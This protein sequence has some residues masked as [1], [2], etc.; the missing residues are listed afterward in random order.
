M[1]AR[2]IRD[3]YRRRNTAVKILYRR[4]RRVRDLLGR[5]ACSQTAGTRACPGALP[6]CGSGDGAQLVVEDAG[7]APGQTVVV[8]GAAGNVGAFAIQIARARDANIV[9]TIRAA[10]DEETVRI[11]GAT[12]VIRSQ[13]DHA[14]FAKGADVVIDTV[15]GRSQGSPFSLVRPSPA[16]LLHQ[17]WRI[18]RRWRWIPLISG[19]GA[20]APVNE[21]FVALIR[22]FQRQRAW[23]RRRGRSRRIPQNTSQ[24]PSGRAC[25]AHPVEAIA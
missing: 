7:V 12:Q 5:H 16:T 14:R 9:G 25:R 2:R 1:N 22:K 23:N 19:D 8:H 24:V 10:K 20:N 15:G 4:L 21:T 3:Y 13:A 6:A 17:P 18:V 11:P